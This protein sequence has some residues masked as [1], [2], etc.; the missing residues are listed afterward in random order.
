MEIGAFVNTLETQSSVAQQNVINLQSSQS[1]VQDADI[2]EQLTAGSGDNAQQS[3]ALSTLV[4][5]NEAP[6]AIVDFIKGSQL[7][8]EG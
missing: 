2:A 6:G 5:T 7:D 3:A 4:Q 8:V 1:S